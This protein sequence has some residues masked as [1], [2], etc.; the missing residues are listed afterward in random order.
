MTLSASAPRPVEQ[1]LTNLLPVLANV[2]YIS[3][4]L[5]LLLACFRRVS[6]GFLSRYC[7]LPRWSGRAWSSCGVTGHSSS[8]PL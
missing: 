8:T 3:L 2:G 6:A 1:R 5:V 4:P 7:P